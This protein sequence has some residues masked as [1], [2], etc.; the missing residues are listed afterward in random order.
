MRY[1]IMEQD[2]EYINVPKIINW[3]DRIDVRQIK[4]GAS[5][6]LPPKIAFNI[7]ENADVVFTDVLTNPFLLYSANIMEAVEIYEPKIPH[8]QIVLLEKKS[9]HTAVY[10]LP[11][12]KK[13][14]CLSGKSELNRDKSIIR[15]AVLEETK[16]PPQSIFQ[17]DGV[18][19]TYT[20]IRLDLVE[21]MLRRG[22]RGI[23]LREAEL[24]RT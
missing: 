1:F 11:I 2:E 18:L 6:K 22:M 21:S 15:H 9:R 16:L 4:P 20:V 14:D 10:Y 8:K 12:L 5:G 13:V 19:S 7:R 24:A 3:Y 23:S 17:L